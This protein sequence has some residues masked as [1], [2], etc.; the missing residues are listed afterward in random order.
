MTKE[1]V[2][3][4]SLLPYNI[5][6]IAVLLIW[7]FAGIEVSSYLVVRLY[8][9]PFVW[10]AYTISIMLAMAPI[11]WAIA[12]IMKH[13]VSFNPDV[14]WDYHN[15]ELEY[16][17]FSKMIADY[18]S[19][20]SHLISRNDHRLLAAALV[21]MA[22]AVI[23]PVSLAAVSVSLVFILPFTYGGLELVYGILLTSYF[24]RSISN[25]A[26]AHFHYENP[27]RLKGA[28]KLLE[29]TPG[30][31]MVGVGFSMGE[32]GGYYAIR[33][34][35]AI[36]RIEGIEAVAKVEI[37]VADI[38]PPLTAFG[39]VSSA[40][41]NDASKRMMELQPGDELSQ[42]EGMVRW[43]ITTYIEEHGSNEILD[44]LMEELGINLN[45]SHD[46]PPSID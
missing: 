34:P 36:G 6:L 43:C 25:E 33:S 1:P 8:S 20:Y 35:A 19:G 29:D 41:E 32:S 44:D 4:S 5:L 3:Y 40:A 10:F 27:A 39:T 16:D 21:M 23:F 13:R 17:E 12:R 38:S 30:F 31:T 14:E 45:P 24:Y 18:T 42:L 46:S 9:D 37:A 11:L 15:Q 2:S 28:C 22:T 26:S 7:V